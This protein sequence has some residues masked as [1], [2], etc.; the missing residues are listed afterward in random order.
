MNRYT[1]WDCKLLSKKRLVKSRHQDTT[2]LHYILNTFTPLQL[3]PLFC[4]TVRRQCGLI[5]WADLAGDE[6]SLNEKLRFIIWICSQEDE[7]T[8]GDEE[9]RVQLHQVFANFH[10]T[11]FLLPYALP[12]HSLPPTMPSPRNLWPL[13][14]SCHYCY[15]A[16]SAAPPN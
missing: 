3:H 10:L 12:F 16:P 15:S 7:D 6:E 9:K 13:L 14:E 1:Q 11:R 8:G 2:T 4:F 5:P